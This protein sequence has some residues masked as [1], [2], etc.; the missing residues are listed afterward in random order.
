LIGFR[1]NA[2]PVIIKRSCVIE[3]DP[4]VGGAHHTITPV[5][6][7][8]I[9]MKKPRLDAAFTNQCSGFPTIGECTIDLSSSQEAEAMPPRIRVNGTI[10][11]NS[12]G[13]DA[14][15]YHFAKPR[16]LLCQ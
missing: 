3:S 13:H 5:A 7:R 10:S 14:T 4:I 1:N 9:P 12:S 2:V 15:T 11:I 8:R 16:F 6:I